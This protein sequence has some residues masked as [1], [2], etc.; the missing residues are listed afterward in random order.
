MSFILRSLFFSLNFYVCLFIPA[1][2][3]D[4]AVWANDEKIDSS[5]QQLIQPVITDDRVERVG[6]LQ[7]VHTTI[8]PLLAQEA[9]SA[10]KITGVKVNPTTTGVELVLESSAG[11]ISQ[12]TTKREGNTLTAD[13]PNA[14]LNLTDGKEFQSVNPTK[15]ITNVSVT[16]LNENS[17]RVIVTGSDAVPAVNVV[18]SST[19]LMLNLTASSPETEDDEIEI[20]VT[21]EQQRGYRVPSAST[22]TGTDTP[23]LE[24]PFSIQV[25]P[26]EVIRDQQAI[27]IKDA[28]SNVSGVAYRGDVQGRSGNTFIIRGF[29]DIQVLRDGFRRFGAGGDGEGTAQPIT[30]VANLERIEVLKGPAS[31][32]YGA[33]EPGGLIN[34]V[35]KQPLSQPFY[36]AELQFG[37]RGL[38]RPRFDISGPLT[39]DRKVLYRLNGLYY[40]LGNFRNLEQNDQKFLIA[41]ALTWKINDRTDLNLSLEYVS[42]TRPADFGIPSKDGKVV[43]VPRDRVITEPN[44]TVSSSSLDISY[45]LEHRID[46]NWKLRNAFRYSSSQYDF[47]VVALPLAFDP[48]TNIVTRS[49]A[50]QDSETKNYTFQTNVV[51]EFATGDVKHTL[52]GGVDYVYRT[53]RTFSRVDFTPRPLDIFNPIYGLAKPAKDSIEPFGGNDSSLSSWGFFLQDQ[54]S[55]FK[56][57][58]LLAGIRYDTF[59]QR[60]VNLPGSSTELGETTINAGAVTPRIGLLYQLSDTLSLYGN[61]S[62][63]F[64][65][66]TAVT[67]SGQPLEPQRGRGY[68]FGIK[69]DLLDSKLFATLAYFDIT[70]QNVAVT[71]PS[72]PLFSIASGEQRSRGIEFDVSG[73]LSPGWKVIASYAYIDGKVTADSDP[74]NVGKKLFGVPEHSASLWTTYEIQSGDLQGLGAGLGFNFVGDRQGDLANTYTV[75][76]YFT[77]NAAIFYKRDNWRVA[78]NFKNIGDVKYIES[79]FGNAAAGNN[80]GDPFTIIGSVSVQF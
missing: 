73:E 31:I 45:R 75:G 42:A 55:I 14:V 13:I 63:S 11:V 24:T 59:S 20:T 68:E 38:V 25:I 39:E 47:G 51:G 35:S 62:Q 70:K 56:N 9:N 15:G 26:Q 77:T 37:S 53:S 80:F 78:L 8:K 66:N 19:G 72:F 21:G 3:M 64:S 1:L 46:D 44:D 16:Q 79:S 76:S 27:Q 17:V 29:S 60:T 18:P 41:P 32:L 23:I 28:L 43:D 57:L 33:I 7:Q 67:A 69:A 36:E 4:R 74:A 6:D 50:S 2:L 54:I 40:S 30:E 5:S 48:A 58:K 12:P 10:V 61:Y 22:A 65:P 52:L 49:L 34:L 71:D